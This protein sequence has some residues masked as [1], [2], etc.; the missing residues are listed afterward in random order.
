MPKVIPWYNP[1]TDGT[2]YMSDVS[3]ADVS[4]ADV[5]GADVSGADVSGA[6]VSG[7]DVSTGVSVPSDAP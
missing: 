4:G 6:D 2:G 5:S 7:A 3:G 1:R